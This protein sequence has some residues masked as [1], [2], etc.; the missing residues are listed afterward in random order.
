M[1][2]LYCLHV[3][4]FLKPIEIFDGICSCTH[5]SIQGKQRHI[6]RKLVK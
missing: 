6:P 1:F 4:I 5:A 2:E 3:A